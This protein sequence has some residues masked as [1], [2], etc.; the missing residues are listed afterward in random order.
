MLIPFAACILEAIGIE[1]W[2]RRKFIATTVG[3]VAA[4]LLFTVEPI[5]RVIP[6][7][8]ALLSRMIPAFPNIREAREALALV[9]RGRS[10]GPVYKT[11]P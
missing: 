8:G 3:L 9:Q 1:A 7:G 11:V 6:H 4:I 10:P 2:P 5:W